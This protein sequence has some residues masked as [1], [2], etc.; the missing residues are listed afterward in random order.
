[1]EV[2]K[3]RYCLL[4]NDIETTSIW[5]NSVRPETGYRVYKEGMPILLDLYAQYDIKSTFFFC[6]DIV[7]LY[8]DIVK[9]ILPY[10]HEV[11]SHGWSHEVNEAFDV[12][13]LEKQIEHLINSKQILE[14]LSGQEVI[15][16]RA[17]ALRVNNFT[18]IALSETGFRIDS[19]IPS[20]RFDFFMSFGSF[21]KFYWLLAPRV[22]YKTATNNLAKKGDGK[23][24]E[25]PLSALIF[26]YLGTTMR[27]FPFFTNMIRNLHHLETS[28]SRKPVVFDIHPNE[29]IDEKSNNRIINNRS[30][31]FIQYL[32]K[33]WI[34]GHLKV[35]NL[36]P[37]AKP[38][39]ESQINFFSNNDYT[40]CTIKDYCR[41]NGLI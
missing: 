5:F 6:G 38:I 14:D 31:S 37:K 23:I 33:D 1:M 25:I 2:N 27:I 41:Y 30:Q 19:S 39:F 34:R 9:M 29:F 40:F 20:Q 11:A 16:F 18:P 12:L 7:R 28:I 10:G 3:K 8:P 35:K 36:G 17:P 21:K 15:S 24:I 26:P 22:P 32:L 13:S 4:T